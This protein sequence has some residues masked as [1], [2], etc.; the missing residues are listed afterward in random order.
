MPLRQLT[1]ERGGNWVAA[2]NAGLREAQG[3]YACFLHQDDL[4]LA[5]RL[6]AI[7]RE[8]ARAPTLIVHPSVFVGPDGS[9]LGSWRCPLP[10]GDVDPGIFAERLIVQN[11]IAV[12]APAFRRDVA[13]RLGGMDEKLWYAA[14]WDFWL[15]LGR[16]GAIR[17]VAEPLAAFR[18]HPGSQT[19]LRKDL[20]ERRSQ[21]EAVL[22]R[23]DAAV[24]PAARRAA[25]FS[26]EVNVA[27]LAAASRAAVPW[28]PL[29]RA[30][31]RLGPASF[32]RYL[33]DSRIVERIR[34]RL[35][36]RGLPAA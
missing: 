23:H 29:I 31:L 16:E 32:V 12:P 36:L 17:H 21:L 6:A 2:T 25:R 30:L 11:F 10:E 9:R 20:S 5:G 15:R 14:D 35:H 8:V 19:V 34:A 24:R 13:L 18:V 33:R 28:S 26:A 3:E 7:A 22:A 1:R 27:L 4:W